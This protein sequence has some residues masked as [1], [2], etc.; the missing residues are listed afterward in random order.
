MLCSRLT[1]LRR[2]Q[3]IAPFDAVG[4]GFTLTK[5]ILYG[6]ESKEESREEEARYEEEGHE[7]RNEALTVTARACTLWTVTPG[8]QSARARRRADTGSRG[9]PSRARFPN[10]TSPPRNIVNSSATLRWRGCFTRSRGNGR[11]ARP[12]KSWV[13]RADIAADRRSRPR[14]PRPH[15]RANADR[16]SWRGQ[17]PPDRPRPWR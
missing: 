15:A 2:D 8:S 6:W 1:V 9:S 4:G 12:A 17:A 10:K 3:M 13:G 16:R 7:A 14:A 11:A 5:G